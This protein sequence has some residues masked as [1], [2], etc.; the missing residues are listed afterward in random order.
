VSQKNL[1]A[2]GSLSEY[3]SC[4]EAI[5]SLLAPYKNAVK[6]II[7]DNGSE[8]F[9][10]LVL[11]TFLNCK[12]YFCD[13]YCSWQRGLNEHTNGFLRQY[14]PKGTSF[15]DPDRKNLKGYTFVPR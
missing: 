1:L 5:K 14:L 9:L 11:A 7:F 2:R 13:P 3:A 12:T 8:F 4:T 10:H 6:T 15:M